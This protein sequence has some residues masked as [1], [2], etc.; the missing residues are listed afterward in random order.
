M[1]MAAVAWL[2]L[3]EGLIVLLELAQGADQP[4]RVAGELDAA[5]VGELLATAGQRQ[6]GERAEDQ[7]TT[8]EEQA[9]GEDRRS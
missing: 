9:G 2:I 8:S 1:H 4:G 6:A 5:H 3:R 7:A